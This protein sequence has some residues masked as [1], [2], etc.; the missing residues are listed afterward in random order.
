MRGEDLAKE[1]GIA[2]GTGSP[3]HARGRRPVDSGDERHDR[4]TPACAGKTFCGP[5]ADSPDW[6]HP[7]MRG[8]DGMCRP[9]TGTQSGSPPHARGR[10][11]FFE[12]VLA[13]VGITPACA[14][15][16]SCSTRSISPGSD[17]PRMRGED[18]MEQTRDF[19]GKGSPPHARGRRASYP[20]RYSTLR[21]TPACAGK[22]TAEHKGPILGWDHPRMRGED[23]QTQLPLGTE[24]GSPPHARGR[25][26]FRGAAPA[27]RGITPACAGKT[28]RTGMTMSLDSGSPPHARG[29]PYRR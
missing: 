20:A 6:D 18:I 14:G 11:F 15:K 4:I 17:H 13:D 25:P 16:T 8:E 5:A 19:H 22:T 2:R 9:R 21:I 1:L 26:L 24:Q 27:C 10:Q 23:T 12:R 28:E 7:R 29:R 3:P